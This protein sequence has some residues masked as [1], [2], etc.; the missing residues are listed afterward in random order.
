[1]ARQF[2]VEKPIKALRMQLSALHQPP[3]KWGWLSRYGMRYDVQLTNLGGEQWRFRVC[4]K[5]VSP[6][7]LLNNYGEVRGVMQALGEQQTAV[8]LKIDTTM[9]FLRTLLQM[10][11]VMVGFV[12][13]FW[14]GWS[15]EDEPELL[16]WTA[17]LLS[18]FVLIAMATFIYHYWRLLKPIKRIFGEDFV[19]SQRS[20]T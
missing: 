10:T 16:L 12:V 11:M 17:L 2:V 18:L 6:L 15:N 9:L 8:V 3:P 1:M 19:H 7:A 20:R 13:G 14:L 5:H 4:R